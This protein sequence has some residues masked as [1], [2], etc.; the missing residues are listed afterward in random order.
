[1]QQAAASLATV[2]TTLATSTTASTP[3]ILTAPPTCEWSEHTCPDGFKY[4]YNCITKESRWENPKELID[5]KEQQLRLPVQRA[6]IQ[7]RVQ[8]LVISTNSACQMH[9]TTTSSSS[10]GW[11]NGSGQS[12]DFSIQ[13]R[14]FYRGSSSGSNGGSYGNRGCSRRDQRGDWN[15]EKQNGDTQSYG[16]SKG[17]DEQVDG[18]GNQGSG[19][20]RTSDS[21]WNK[22]KP[23][24]DNQSSGWS[25]DA[26]ANE[27]DQR[28]DW[29]REKQNGDT[30][31][32][33]WSKGEDDQVDGW[34]NQGSGN[35]RTS[36]SGWNKGKLHGD[37]Q[38]SGLS[39]D[40]NANAGDQVGGWGSQV[41]GNKDTCNSDWNR[42]KSHADNESFGWRT[43]ISGETGTS[44]SEGWA[45]EQIESWN[46]S[47][48]AAKTVSA[49]WN[50][51]IGAEG[52]TNK[53]DAQA[54]D[55]W[56][57]V[58]MNSLGEE[59]RGSGGKGGW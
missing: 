29:N 30:Q 7:S 11:Y 27:G 21:R 12:A 58:I 22:G 36:D 49:G 56:A 14:G 24:G 40:A 25:K 23:H 55:P 1:M 53:N 43:R 20:N 34:G 46:Q 51:T 17:E 45:G 33:G 35:Y 10:Q 9:L 18:W 57:K 48:V 4:Y 44:N 19:N 16:W 15:R 50:K 39:K 32:L 31:S 41:S 3:H 8:N 6:H 13:G 37:D 26:N 52:K 5:S 47:N 38:S 2:P 59:N 54:D 28:S 42:E